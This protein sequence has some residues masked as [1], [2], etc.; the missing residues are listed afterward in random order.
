MKKNESHRMRPRF[1]VVHQG[2]I[3]DLILS[4]P[5]LYALR[6]AFPQHHCEV[7]GYASTV[8]LLHNRFYVD[9]IVSIDKAVFVSLYQDEPLNDPD[10][11]D[12][13]SRFQHVIVFGGEVHTEVV[14]KISLA[15][16]GAVFR[17]NPFP[18]VGGVH[19]ID[20]QLA[21]LQSFGIK[22]CLF[23][24]MLFLAPHDKERALCILSSCGIDISKEVIVAVH[25]G[26]GSEEKNWPTDYFITC[27]KNISRLSHCRIMLLEG[28]AEQRRCRELANACRE[29]DLCI[30]RE[31]E[32]V[33][34]PALLK[35]CRVYIGN[36]SGITHIAAA[37]GIPTIA[38]FGPT[39]PDVWGPRGQEVYIIR[40]RADMQGWK[41]PSPDEVAQ[42]AISLLVK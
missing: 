15:T 29:M 21:Q 5:A 25:P 22:P 18:K 24:P 38:L 12:Y 37:T 30:V 17:I 11:R 1:L 40:E 19:V 16:S 8:S 14:R 31:P 35:Y 26:S 33:L 6:S 41:W 42:K 39:D 3:G 9:S 2:A 34:I 28:P 20:Y 13:F 23:T 32:L 4:L 10:L 36:D 27:L 7:L